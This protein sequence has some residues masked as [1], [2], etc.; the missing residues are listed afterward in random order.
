MVYSDVEV[1][2]M[3]YS[4]AYGCRIMKGAIERCSAVL[5]VE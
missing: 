3:I 4:D 1:C 2:R 5:R